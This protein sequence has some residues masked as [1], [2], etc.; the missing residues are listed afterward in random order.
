MSDPV[1]LHTSPV[2][3]LEYLGEYDAMVV[4]RSKDKELC[5]VLRRDMPDEGFAQ[6]CAKLRKLVL[7]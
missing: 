5:F 1:D 3:P 7:G 4:M 6:T 2:I